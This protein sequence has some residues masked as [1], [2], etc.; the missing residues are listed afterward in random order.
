MDSV[1]VSGLPRMRGDRPW[2]WFGLCL[3]LWF[4]PHARGSTAEA[5]AEDADWAVYPA[6]AGIDPANSSCLV[7]GRRLPRMRGDRPDD[8]QQGLIPLMFTPHARGSTCP[9][10]LW[11]STS[12]VY[13]ACAGIDPCSCRCHAPP[14]CLPRMRGD[15]PLVKASADHEESFTPHARGSTV[16][17]VLHGRG[18]RVYPACAGIDLEGKKDRTGGVR[19][20]RMRGDRPG[21]QVRPTGIWLFTPHARGS[22]LRDTTCC[23]PFRV[24]PACAGIDRHSKGVSLCVFGLP[25]MRGDR[26]PFFCT[27]SLSLRFTP[28]AR[29]STTATPSSREPPGVYPACAGIDRYSTRL[30]DLIERLPRMRGDRPCLPTWPS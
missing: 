24:Y 22:T 20:P 26:P 12:R 7:V 15:R 27:W 11:Q 16:D 23:R 4:T 18:D 10:F 25:R 9:S 21:L 2:V 30:V 5:E 17:P 1:S 28:H 29:G 3:C 8:M 14:R 19:L 6:C 13:P